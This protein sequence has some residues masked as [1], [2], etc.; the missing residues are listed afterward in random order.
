MHWLNVCESLLKWVEKIA[1][2]FQKNSK[3][4]KAPKQAIK[5]ASKKAKRDKVRPGVIIIQRMH[6]SSSL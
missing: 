6:S 3:K 2:K 1:S 5:E 4:Q